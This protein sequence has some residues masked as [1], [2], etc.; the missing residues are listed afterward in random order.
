MSGLCEFCD[1]WGGYIAKTND[2][3]SLGLIFLYDFKEG[4]PLHI[5]CFLAYLY[6]SEEMLHKTTNISNV[7]VII[8]LFIQIA[9]ENRNYFA[10]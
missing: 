7:T 5:Q 10:T 8:K 6:F 4:S 3:F 1:E 2:F 9:S